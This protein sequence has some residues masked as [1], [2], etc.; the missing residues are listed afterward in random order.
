MGEKAGD[1]APFPLTD[2]D[3]WVLSQTDEEFKYH[4]WDEL[5]EI[6]SK[7]RY[8]IL[9]R[10]LHDADNSLEIPTTSRS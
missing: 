5:R 8:W 7:S 4:D 9:L 3:K 6:V 1:D 10:G 2:V